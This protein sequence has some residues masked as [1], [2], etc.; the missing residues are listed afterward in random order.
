VSVT[1]AASGNV[2][3]THVDGSTQDD[4]ATAADYTLQ[5]EPDPVVVAPRP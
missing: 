5:V 2:R 3:V 4:V 1:V